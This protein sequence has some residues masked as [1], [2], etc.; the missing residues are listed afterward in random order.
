MLCMEMLASEEVPA[1]EGVAFMSRMVGSGGCS[2][3]VDAGRAR[4]DEIEGAIVSD[5]SALRMLLS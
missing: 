3:T 5:G 4:V 2:A 1:A